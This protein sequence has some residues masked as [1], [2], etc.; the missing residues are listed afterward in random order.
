MTATGMLSSAGPRNQVCSPR[1]RPQRKKNPTTKTKTTTKTT[2]MNNSRPKITELPAGKSWQA[3]VTER[4]D[5][6]MLFDARLCNPNGDPDAGNMARI[7][8]DS[9]KGLVTDVCL[10]RKQRRSEEHT[11]E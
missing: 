1:R 8:A 5:I 11:S 10:T 6:V 4:H 7:E 3:P 9:G 2:T